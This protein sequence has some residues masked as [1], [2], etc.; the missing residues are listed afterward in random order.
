MTDDQPSLQDAL[1]TRMRMLLARRQRVRYG[2]SAW[3][4]L[5]GEIRLLGRAY[6]AA[7]DAKHGITRPGPEGVQAGLCRS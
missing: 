3:Q 6:G 1:I 5:S 2:L 4:R 7:V